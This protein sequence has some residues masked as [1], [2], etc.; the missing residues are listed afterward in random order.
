LIKPKEII[1]KKLETDN[2]KIPFAE[3]K[4]DKIKIY[5]NQLIFGR[6]IKMKLTD[7]SETFKTDLQD[8]E[9]IVGYL[10]LALTEGLPTFLVALK[11]VIQANEEVK[12]IP[13]DDDF[14]GENLSKILSD[15]GN[16]QFITISKILHSLG[17]KFSI[18]TCD[19]SRVI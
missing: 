6:N 3:K 19:D 5:K 2:G 14:G 11:E 8:S 10:E 13:Q 17:L 9:F 12:K 18:T 4:A 15:F 7:I 1:V 16:P